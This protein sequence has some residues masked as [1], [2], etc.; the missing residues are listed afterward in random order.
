MFPYLYCVIRIRDTS[1]PPLDDLFMF[2]LVLDHVRVQYTDHTEP[3]DN[4]NL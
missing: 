4:H 3:G 1:V 2:S